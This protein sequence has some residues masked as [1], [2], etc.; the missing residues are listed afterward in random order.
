MKFPIIN[1][2][3]KGAFVFLLI[4]SIVSF[5]AIVLIINYANISI[6]DIWQDFA[7]WHKIFIVFILL[8]GLIGC[9]IAMYLSVTHVEINNN[10]IEL[11]FGNIVI[12]KMQWKEI[13]WVETFREENIYM[14]RQHIAVSKSNKWEYKEVRHF[15]IQNLTRKKITFL[16]D[17]KAIALIKQHCDCFIYGQNLIEENK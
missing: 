7:I 15:F 11:H 16:F 2:F 17:A 10:G 14:G 12:N 8:L 3:Q 4:M 6:D 1:K 5:V 13:Q 9:S